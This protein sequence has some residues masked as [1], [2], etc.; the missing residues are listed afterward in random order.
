MIANYHTHTPLCRHADGE[1][2]DFVDNAIARGLKIFGFSDHAPHWFPGNYYSHMRMY[3]QQFP[4]YC[5][6]VRQLSRDYQG[7]IQIPLGLEVEYYPQ[8]FPRLLQE[9]RDQ[10]IEYFLLGQ[11]WIGNE[12]NE[13]YCGAPHN[14]ES[15]LARYCAQLAD[16]MQTGLFSYIAH[17]D[18]IHYLGDPKIYEKHIRW[19]CRE[20]NANNIPLELN[21]LGMLTQ[22]HYPNEQFWKIAAEENC[23]VVFGLD[24]HTP[25]EVTEIQVE[26]SAQR[27]AQNF[28]LNIVETVHLRSIG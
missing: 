25:E 3:P 19:L 24:A 14:D 13:P 4:E 28:G 10:G 18:L 6:Q 7:Q 1:L 27:F 8:L 5:Q 23:T 9:A 11:H 2:A 21:F 17:P 15:I 22:R 26:R 20:A 16:G 12:E